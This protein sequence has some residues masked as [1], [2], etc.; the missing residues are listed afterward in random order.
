MSDDNDFV[1][2]GAST[3]TEDQ[4]AI[5]DIAGTLYA[6]AWRTENDVGQTNIAVKFYNAVGELDV[7]PRLTVSD[8]TGIV[9]A[10]SI[11][12]AGDGYAVVWEE[13]AETNANA[14]LKVRYVGTAGLIGGEVTLGTDGHDHS[15]VTSGF[16]ILDP[17]GE[18]IS[19]GFNVAWI[20]SNEPDGTG[21]VRFQRFQLP[22]NPADPAGDPLTPVPVGIDGVEGG[23]AELLG[24][25]RD[26]AMTVTHDG[27]A[28]VA[29]IDGDNNV[30]L[31]IRNADGTVPEAA[32]GFPQEEGQ[33]LDNLG[34]ADAGSTLRI[35][36]INGTT[37]FVLAW[38]VDA[39]NDDGS[40]I[41]QY[42]I[43]NP[44][45]IDNTWDAAPVQS[46][47][48]PTGFN[49]EFGLVGLETDP[50][51][52]VLTL[53]A[54]DSDGS[55]EIV[56]VAFDASGAASELQSAV[57]T[58][59]AGAQNAH[60]VTSLTG[61]RFVVAFQDDSSDAGGDIRAQIMDTRA[62]G[63]LLQGDDEGARARV[64]LLIGTTGD[65]TIEGGQLADEL[66]GAMGDD[67]LNGGA[68]SDLIDGGGNS[69]LGDVAV[70]S[71][72]RGDYSIAYNGDG[73]F[74]VIDNRDLAPGE[75]SD[76]A[77]LVRNV[78]FLKFQDGT[79]AISEF[80][81]PVSSG[82]PTAWALDNKDLEGFNL[83]GTS[84]PQALGGVS[85]ADNFGEFYGVAWQVQ[86]GGSKNIRVQLFN[87][88]G[89]A[90]E[91]LPAPFNV[92]DGDGE[93]VS[94][95]TIGGWGDGYVIVWQEMKDGSIEL[96][97]R[98]TG[99]ESI[100]GDE[101]SIHVDEA[102]IVQG[103]PVIAAYEIVEPDPN[104]P[105]EEII[106]SGFNVLWEQTVLDGDTPTTTI[107]LQ[108]F[109]VPVDELGHALAPLPA[110][111]DGKSGDDLNEPEPIGTGRFPSMAVAHDGETIVTWVDEDG[112]I[113]GAIY[114]ADG[115]KNPT[116]LTDIG[117]VPAGP[118]GQNRP[119]QVIPLGAGNFGIVWVEDAG[120]GHPVIKAQVYT[121]GG[122][123][124][125][126][127]P[128]A[129]R[130]VVDE[131]G[132]TGEFRIAGL[133]EDNEGFIVAFGRADAHGNGVFV[134]HVN[135][136]GL[137]VGDPA[138]V[139][140]DQVGNQSHF[141]IG[142]LVSDRLVVAYT[143]G[144]TAAGGDVMVQIMDTR[145]PDGESI[146][147]DLIRPDGTLQE[148][149]DEIYG[150]VGDDFIDGR[151]R[152]DKAVG[153]LGHDTVVGG[154]GNDH[155][156]GGEDIVN[157]TG[158]ESDPKTDVDTV[159]YSTDKTRYAIW[160]N[161][162]GSYT[163]K[164]MRLQDRGRDPGPDG[165]DAIYDFEQIQFGGLSGTERLS[166][167]LFAQKLPDEV[168]SGGVTPGGTDSTA[169]FTVNVSPT[170]P[171]DLAYTGG[172]QDKPTV[173]A[174]EDNFVIVWHSG[175]TLYAKPYNVLGHPDDQF[176]PG[177]AAG[178]PQAQ[179]FTL[180][181]GATTLGDPQVVMA[182]DLGFLTTWQE[183]TDT[184]HT[185]IRM[186]HTSALDGVVGENPT[187]VSPPEDSD[188][189]QHSAVASGY[190]IV[191][192]NNDTLEFG[193]FVAWVESEDPSVAG[194]IMLQRFDVYSVAKDG[195]GGQER[196]PQ[197]VELDGGDGDDK[198]ENIGFGRDPS[199]ISLHDGEQILTYIDASNQVQLV[200]LVPGTD[201]TT[202]VTE[203]GPGPDFQP[204]VGDLGPA[205]S[206]QII[207]MGFNF[208]VVWSDEGQLHARMYT[209]TGTS[210][211]PGGDINLD[212][213][214]PPGAEYKVMP[215]GEADIAA[216]AI[217]LVAW[218]EIDAGRTDIKVQQFNAAGGKEGPAL[219]V[220]D[221]DTNV[222]GGGLGGLGV[223]G[224]LDGRVVVAYEG[225]ADN[226]GSDQT[227]PSDIVAR[228]LD[229]RAP[230][231]VIMGAREGAGR[232]VLVGTAGNDVMDG[233]VREDELHGGLGDDVVIGGSENDQLFGE[234]HNDTL[235][236]GSENDQLF[237]G[238][239]DDTL[240]GGFGRDFMDGG[241]GI[242]D[243]VSYQGEFASFTID[244]ALKNALGQVTTF[245]NRNP[246]TG[247]PSANLVAEDTSV[248]IENVTGGEVRDIISGDEKANI[249]NGRG[250]DDDLNGRGGND[251]IT[252][253]AGDD[254][255]T[256]GDGDDTIIWN[257]GD[258]RDVI[259]G[260]AGGSNSV[261]DTDTVQFNGDGTAE[262]YR[263]YA[264][265]YYKDPQNGLVGEYGAIGAQTEIVVI[266]NGVIIAELENIDEI[267]IDGN[268]IN[269]STNG[270]TYIIKGD[271]ESTD[272][273]PGTITV[274]GTASS[275]TIDISSLQSEHRIVFKSKGGSD[276]II[277]N[278]R[279]Q[280]VIEL[281]DGA[282]FD[283]YE[284][285][286]NP[287][288]TI[289]LSNG[290]NS[291]TFSGGTIPT[292]RDD[293]DDVPAN[294]KP[295]VAEDTASGAED[296][297]IT[298]QVSGEDADED[299]LIYAIHG[300]TPSGLTFNE[301][302]SY[303]Y[304]P[305][306]NFHGE[307][308]FQYV[309]KDGVLVSDPKTVTITVTPVNDAPVAVSDTISGEANAKLTI[310]VLA[311][312]TDVDTGDT[313][314]LFSV[315]VPKGSVSIEDGQVVF[316]PGTDFDDLKAGATETVTIDYT[317]KD[318]QGA[319]S[320]STV[321]VTVT[322]VND[323]A[324]AEDGTA[325]GKEEDL[326][327][328]GQV[329]ATDVDGDPLTYS[330]VQGPPLEQ[331]TLI[332]KDDGSYSFVPAKDYN[333]EV[334]FTYKASDGTMDSN[335]ATV[336]IT[337]EAQ[338]D[339][340]VAEDGTASGKED[341]LEIK[342]QVVA[343]DV[344]G[345]PLTYSLVQ[346]P[347]L[348]QGTLILKDDGSYSFVPAKDYN[349]EVSFQYVANDG[350]VDSAPQTV[351]ITVEAQNDA[352]TGR[353]AMTCM[354]GTLT[355]S[356][357]LADVDGM[358]RA[359]V[360]IQWQSSLDGTTWSDIAGA[361]SPTFAPTA[362]QE[363]LQVRALALY[364]DQGGTEEKV[365]STQVARIGSAAG[366][367]LNGTE[368]NDILFGLS[369][370][371]AIESAGGHDVIEAGG[372]ADTVGGG[373][374]RDTFLASVDDGNDIYDGGRGRDVYSL[375]GTS[376]RA[377][378][379]LGAGTATSLQ[380]GSDSLVG[381]ESVIGSRGRDL[382]MAGAG[383]HELTGGRGGDVFRFGSAQAAQ[384]DVILDFQAG[385]DCLHLRGID[386]D[387]G[388]RGNQA[389]TLL[390]VGAAFTE[391]GQLRYSYE[392]DGTVAYTLIQGNVDGDVGVDF[393]IRLAGH[394]VFTTGDIVL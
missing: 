105:D 308:E 209:A 10:P 46:Y 363:G 328:K 262:E 131:V 81:P 326:E 279:P 181:E 142:G 355:A 193:A 102:A 390:E 98:F 208:A 284:V 347:P 241:A 191:D 323:A 365:A 89:S 78:E 273:D 210:W 255:I 361:L 322:G 7:L 154:S 108:R 75:A 187:E 45:A 267:E 114:N 227:D 292:I 375:A 317:I 176:G 152:D 41:V 335:V 215:A 65:D 32:I 160:M 287:D 6:V 134:Q 137:P 233:R 37:G 79:V 128:G 389:F 166:P 331:G 280:D 34:S 342:G 214:V 50:S 151:G 384:G 174:L 360:S 381:I 205:D 186:R 265:G 278:F 31:H 269:P 55:A 126:W 109:M 85:I 345:D 327:I 305:A 52:F 338:N 28:V 344:D 228:I 242:N 8:G 304:V 313:R 147:G 362:A 301:D 240:L 168:T 207:S 67:V 275:D 203:F 314:T 372:G 391:A 196:A 115:T 393:E 49:G 157:G 303:S 83:S 91:F 243:T 172:E 42:Q 47:T 353:V 302:G 379:D 136:L 117:T 343:T 164:D 18:L 190:E 380:T 321:T 60:V 293:D 33:T 346:G 58:T 139:N 26:V 24:F 25:G 354:P 341:D 349:G 90:D 281:P 358:S 68:G 226:T 20:S 12:G 257:S 87:S 182:G 159:V 120:A 22:V 38:T 177:D 357:T 216:D 73:S 121:V 289:T 93:I 263:I 169:D 80:I 340:A 307:V 260:S 35:S 156:Y 334:T 148:R 271:F 370:D 69:P 371:D 266:R 368:A 15:A 213:T 232:D 222:V 315:S 336:T 220:N 250:G 2:S 256:G 76:G 99:P 283:D 388:T 111:I 288:G 173:A 118:E 211:V 130:T 364:T 333:G 135:G 82:T 206:V 230:G 306:A 61:D 285:A 27:E 13:K 202:G 324:V 11:A 116:D 311:N 291:I 352:A 297:T 129:V 387:T 62:P 276:T 94:D 348:E 77:D 239:G 29:W 3:V 23:E 219:T 57:N 367:P 261:A 101:F 127:V 217:F 113:Q 179:I 244:L 366:G 14:D 254:T 378:V 143:S 153:G 236:G 199:I 125:T 248:E 296:T 183:T 133:G 204:V 246:D 218:E 225:R 1:V 238:A 290:S 295:V 312:D 356:H 124:G 320:S 149:R 96:R 56:S 351:V 277:G 234:D 71:G 247:A 97:G 107:M 386:A 112:V 165:Q 4:P 330:L 270:D 300:S 51:G 286:Q 88:D 106:T 251:T 141:G 274:N 231:A 100:V 74:T 40:R 171:D 249:L 394:K 144:D 104:D 294:H 316:D 103:N 110:G 43:F 170:S 188:D 235:I 21:Q 155:L 318:A 319:S 48:P 70:Y 299:E 310:D 212:I 53:G 309:A 123:A 229:T 373:G 192:A 377:T 122:A 44:G 175:G 17:T 9:F 54:T 92:N 84:G 223:A 180:T 194:K 337:V 95:P 282:D 189:D 132:F 16:E 19:T 252:G 64:D 221:E 146:F 86:E 385:R 224:L 63:L 237:G 258:G 184:D 195:T 253:G 197:E 178:D 66:Y 382:F 374:G 369:G 72:N 39:G 138:R 329:L 350:T 259:V 376:A 245:S 339:A 198:A 158:V 119:V 5:A 36:A 264:A 359:S 272:L 162:D 167:D 59:T 383:A 332:L 200:M 140:A 163:V 392:T 201:S 30:H 145:D 150:T 268:K 325:S 161:G 298:G 185:V